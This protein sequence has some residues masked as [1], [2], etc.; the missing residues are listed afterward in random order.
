[1]RKSVILS[2]RNMVGDKHKTEN[3]HRGKFSGE[4]VKTT[5]IVLWVFPCPGRTTG[6]AHP[7]NTGSGWEGIA[8]SVHSA[9]SV[10]R[11][12]FTQTGELDIVTC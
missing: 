9:G 1:M 11:V 12:S 5:R 10:V 4:N 3:Y 7:F 2:I 6:V 8:V